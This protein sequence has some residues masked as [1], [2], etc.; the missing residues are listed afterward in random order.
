[1][2]PQTKNL[3][4]RFYYLPHSIYLLASL[5]RFEEMVLSIF[6]TFYVSYVFLLFEFECISNY[7]DSYERIVRKNLHT[8]FLMIHFNYSSILT[9]F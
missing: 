8:F 7:L 4:L 9:Y 6:I 3:F 2:F 1:M 5:A